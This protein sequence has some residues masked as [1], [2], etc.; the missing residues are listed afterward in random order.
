MSTPTETP[1]E[2]IESLCEELRTHYQDGEDR[3]LRVAA[4]TM[5]VALDQFRRWGGNNWKNL[6]R[7]YTEM[8]LH[9]PEKFDRVLLANRSETPAIRMH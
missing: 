6:V 8:A 2:R 5:L 4:K 9:D 1:M 7:E 3:E